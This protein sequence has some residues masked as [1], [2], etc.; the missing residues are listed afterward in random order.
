MIA[1]A[2]ARVI[3]AENPLEDEDRESNDIKALQ[4]VYGLVLSG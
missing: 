3:E 1:L 4:Y 2:R